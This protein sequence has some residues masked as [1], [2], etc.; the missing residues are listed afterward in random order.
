[1]NSDGNLF[2]KILDYGDRIKVTKTEV[3]LSKKD[4]KLSN[5]LIPS[6]ST[7]FGDLVSFIRTPHDQQHVE[8]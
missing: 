4:E 3:R 7:Q 2:F 1:M 8:A 5:C 6:F